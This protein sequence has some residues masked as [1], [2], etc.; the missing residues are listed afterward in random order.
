MPYRETGEFANIGVVLCCPELGYLH[1]KME[2]RKR[3][4]IFDFFPELHHD[5]LVNGLKAVQLDL[6]RTSTTQ[7]GIN[8]TYLFPDTILLHFRE[9]VKHKEGLFQFSEPRMT[10]TKNPEET[11]NNIFSDV[12]LR[13]FAE[14]KEYHEHVMVERIKTSL[15]EWQLDTYYQKTPVGMPDV[16]CVNFP[17]AYT[18]KGVVLKAIKPLN[19]NKDTSSMIYDHGDDWIGKI[20]RLDRN[21]FLPQDL[22]FAVEYPDQDTNNRK[23]ANDIC[24]E[25]ELLKI[26]VIPYA[27]RD[28]IMQ[29][30]RVS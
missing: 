5:V 21:K 25:L 11:L 7:Q 23:A 4:R 12:V 1:F 2:H 6:K 15:K 9:I 16:Y 26:K 29:W 22:M 28:A 14:S 24:K 19:L 8:Q 10:L 30:A 20:K 13:Q 27:S 3:K 18:V 17:L